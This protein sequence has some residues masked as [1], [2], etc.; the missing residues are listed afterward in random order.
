MTTP[1]ARDSKRWGQQAL[2]ALQ[3]TTMH[4]RPHDSADL[5]QLADALSQRGYEATVITLGPCLA[6]R[7]P[8]TV[9]PQMIYTTDGHL[10]WN[11]TQTR[12]SASHITRAADTITCSLSRVLAWPAK[13]PKEAG[14]SAASAV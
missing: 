2:G 8:G 14:R 11:T 5:G 7:I 10:W 12:A 4:D 1:H 6:I 9:L 13:S 3:V